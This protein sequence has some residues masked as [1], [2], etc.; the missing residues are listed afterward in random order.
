MKKSTINI[1][2]N[3]LQSK[4]ID[5]LE[6]CNYFKHKNLINDRQLLVIE[7]RIKETTLSKIAILMGISKGRV[8][9]I[10]R[11]MRSKLIHPKW[12]KEFLNEK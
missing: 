9:E 4:G 1:A 12:I 2:K 7:E 11:S 8:Y 3:I 5:I 6:M 10:E